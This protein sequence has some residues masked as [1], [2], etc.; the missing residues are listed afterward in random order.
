MKRGEKGKGRK[1]KE[2]DP[3]TRPHL[4][5]LFSQTVQT[6][7]A[8]HWV[9]QQLGT[10]ECLGRKKGGSR[11]EDRQRGMGGVYLLSFLFCCGRAIGPVL[12]AISLDPWWLRPAFDNGPG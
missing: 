8:S 7:P 2:R 5:S 3:K 11:H 1:K 9:S 6:A 10:A 4:L 12:P